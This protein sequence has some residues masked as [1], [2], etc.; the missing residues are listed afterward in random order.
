MSETTPLPPG[1]ARAVDQELLSGLIAACMRIVLERFSRLPVEHNSRLI[2]QVSKDNPGSLHSGLRQV[3]WYRT[4]AE[5]QAVFEARLSDE[6]KRLMDYLWDHG[7][8][9]LH[10]HRFLDEVEKARRPAAHESVEVVAT[11]QRGLDHV[12]CQDLIEPAR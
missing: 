9:N 6:G 3:P 2:W 10:T 4:E 11:Q 5:E 1:P 12:R 8:P 7:R